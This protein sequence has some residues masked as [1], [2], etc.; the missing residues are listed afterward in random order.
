MALAN[1]VAHEE[2]IYNLSDL[3]W[4]KKGMLLLRK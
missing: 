1:D 2:P 4:A 3:K